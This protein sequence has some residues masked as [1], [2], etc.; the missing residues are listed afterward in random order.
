MKLSANRNRAETFNVLQV[1]ID[2]ANATTI[3]GDGLLKHHGNMAVAGTLVLGPENARSPSVT[4]SHAQLLLLSSSGKDDFI[5]AQGRDD[6]LIFQ[7]SANGGITSKGGLNAA[8]ATFRVEDGRASMLNAAIGRNLDVNGSAFIRG[9]IQ[10]GPIAAPNVHISSTKGINI[11]TSQ[12]S[13]AVLQIMHANDGVEDE[14]VSLLRLMSRGANTRSLVQAIHNDETV[15]DI[16]SVGFV[17]MAHLQLKSG[18]ILVQSGGL[19]VQAGGVTVSGGLTLKSGSLHLGNEGLDL[20][21]LSVSNSI[22]YNSSLLSA[23]SALPNYAGSALDLSVNSTSQDFSFIVARRFEGSALFRVDGR[24]FIESTSGAKL[25]GE[26]GLHVTG[27]SVLEGGVSFPRVTVLAG[28]EITIS[29]ASSFLEILDDGAVAANELLLCEG[30]PR[31]GHVLMVSNRDA[32]ATTGLADIGPGG[33]MLLIYDQGEWRGIQASQSSIKELLDINKLTASNDLA[34]GDVS[35]SAGLLLSTRLSKGS[36]VVSDEGGLLTNRANLKFNKGVLSSPA[37]KTSKLLSNV[38]VS[39][40]EIRNAKIYDARI[41][42]TSIVATDLVISGLRG[43]AYFDANGRLCNS[44]TAEFDGNGNL[45][46]NSLHA[47]LDARGHEISNAVLRSG[48]VDMKDI[49]A[50]KLTTKS[51]EA[52]KIRLEEREMRPETLSFLLGVDS[53]G[54]LAPLPPSLDKQSGV[55]TSVSL[56]SVSMD[57]AQVADELS[58]KNLKITGLSVEATEGQEADSFM[59]ISHIGDVRRSPRTV[60]LQGLLDSLNSADSV[61]FPSGVSGH[62][63]VEATLEAQSA[64]IGTLLVRDNIR[65][66]AGQASTLQVDSLSASVASFQET[67]SAEVGKFGL[68]KAVGNE[69]L[70]LQDAIISNALLDNAT[71]TNMDSIHSNR[72]D[73]TSDAHFGGNVFVGRSLTVQGSVVGSGAYVDS[74][75]VRFKKHIRPFQGAL[76]KLLALSAVRPRPPFLPIPFCRSP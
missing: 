36:L 42:D 73:V 46:V 10:V 35:F 61:S 55:R 67:I 64:Q 17:R 31:E 3:R 60:V 69:T 28:K 32:Q 33:V 24:G 29:C 45:L 58:T 76:D 65:F 72:L 6:N 1:Q 8:N 37:L 27:H 57:R 53:D 62:F 21:R 13:G 4:A 48:V 34:I 71:I 20:S 2:G 51:L 23:K 56:G 40:N 19:S 22:H 14:V 54:N 41:S 50:L 9:D 25:G 75:D 44:T 68:L 16:D 38:D 5:Q 18:G 26:A 39:G 74:S 7:L 43:L 63:R 66:S 11:Q 12:T 47:P 70:I 30:D 59:L 49:Q 15:F 52:G